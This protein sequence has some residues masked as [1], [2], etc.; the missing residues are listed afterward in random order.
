MALLGTDLQLLEVMTLA[1]G[2]KQTQIKKRRQRGELKTMEQNGSPAPG[3]REG[4]EA[5]G[6]VVF[7]NAAGVAAEGEGQRFLTGQRASH[8]LCGGTSLG[9]LGLS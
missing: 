2:T 3:S 1:F 5:V 6:S 9:A 7:E 4:K 8:R